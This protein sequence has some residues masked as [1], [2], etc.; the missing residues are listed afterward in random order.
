MKDPML[1][2]REVEPGISFDKTHPYKLMEGV[3]FST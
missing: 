1:V 3:G 2:S